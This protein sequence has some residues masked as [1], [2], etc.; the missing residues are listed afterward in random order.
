MLHVNSSLRIPRSTD[1]RRCL[2][3]ALAGVLLALLLASACRSNRGV[4]GETMYVSASQT[5]LRDHV[6]AVYNRIGTLKNG[7][8]VAVLEKQK[9]FARVRTEAGQEGWVELR[10]L[11]SQDTWDGFQKLA[12]SV[13]SFPAQGRAATRAEL[14]MHLEP[15]RET[16]TLYQLAEGDKVEILKR[17]A[18]ER[19][20]TEELA[21][22]RAA[23]EPALA[24]PAAS[25]PG[26]QAPGADEAPKAYDDFWLVRDKQGRVGWVLARVVELDIP[27]DVA[28]L[29]EG[30]RIQAAFVLNT[31]RD[32]NRDVP[33]YLVLLNEPRDGI[34]WDFNQVRVFTWGLRRHRYETAYREHFIMGYLPAR[35]GTEDFGGKDGVQPY[36]V[37]REQN[38]DGSVSERKF[39]LASFRVLRVLAPGE[40]QPRAAVVARPAAR[41][42]ARVRQRRPPR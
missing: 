22:H 7:E 26:A 1:S 33:Q 4:G 12:D 3:L 38:Q 40:P 6:S 15:G 21:A 17:A 13:R 42:K 36:F 41:P 8:R 23:G 10:S 14:N 25:G 5:S 20:S 30:Q 19:P 28:Q 11:A 16:E 2:R 18:A 39:R 9:R 32:G 37:I 27:L 24:A 34:A 31:V 35:I 29:A